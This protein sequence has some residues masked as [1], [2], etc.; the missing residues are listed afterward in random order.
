MPTGDAPRVPE[1]PDLA[2]LE[3][4]LRAKI[5]VVGACW[6]W[7]GDRDKDGYGRSSRNG[8]TYQ[9]HRL[10]YEMLVGPVP[11]GLTLDHL[12]SVRHCVRPIHLEP[13]TQAE[14]VA[15]SDWQAA[16]PNRDDALNVLVFASDRDAL[17]ALG[18]VEIGLRL[19]DDRRDNPAPA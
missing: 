5:T 19:V 8:R 12:C 13:V 17:A 14:N 6:H 9:A 7:G 15:R 16:P 10:I 11:E 1:D 2:A 4:R 3:P 18:A